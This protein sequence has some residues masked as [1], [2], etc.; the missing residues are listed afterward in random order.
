VDEGLETQDL[1]FSATL[2]R[3]RGISAAEGVSGVQVCVLSEELA[4]Q[5]FKNED[6][7]G[8]QV[9]LGG[10]PFTVIGL[11]RVP[12]SDVTE[13]GERPR[14]DG[15]PYRAILPIRAIPSPWF[16]FPGIH[17]VMRDPRQA[18]S[19]EAELKAAIHEI[20]VLPSKMS[21]LVYNHAT[22]FAEQEQEG[23]MLQLRAL[24]IG[25]TG[26]WV[27]LVGLVNMLFASFQART[28]EIGLLR[29]LGATR[30]NI[31]SGSMT[32]G[33]AIAG[34][35]SA[36]GLGLALILA[37]TLGKAA[38]VPVAIPPTW[39]V[40]VVGFTVLASC[41]AALLPAAQAAGVNP[42]EALRSE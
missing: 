20:A 21:A 18:K 6:P 24:L 11:A 4:Q 34:I 29:A 31:I 37:P 16:P 10:I 3:G 42:S 38:E 32:E 40:I 22:Q 13:L 33:V 26:L 41:V 9:R 12:R 14:S 27:A 17:L 2:A 25:S 19:A 36:F 8:K 15:T 5:L 28:R 30:W 39:I 7:L 1:A 35:G 23:A